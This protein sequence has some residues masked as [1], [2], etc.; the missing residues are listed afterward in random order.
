V[1]DLSKVEAGRMDL[2]LEIF[3]VA[4]LLDDVQATVQPLVAHK[5]NTLLVEST[6]DV[7]RMHA[8]VTK[9]RQVLFNL[10]SNAAK[11]TEHGTVSL[12]ASREGATLC[13]RVSDTGIGIAPQN[14]GKLFQPFTQVDASTTRKYGGTGLGLALT[15]RF[16]EL[17]GGDVTV[18]STPG[19]GTTFTVTLPD[20]LEFVPALAT[21][22]PD[23]VHRT[24]PAVLVV[25]DDPVAREL[26]QG[27]L[28]REGYAVVC[29]AS[30]PDGLRLARELR[31]L[32]ITL[33]VLMPGS[34][35]WA[36]LSQL[37]ADPDTCDIPVVMVSMLDERR[38]GFTLG[39]VDYLTKPV[40]RARLAATLRRFH[41]AG[42]RHALVVED[43]AWTREA[44]C[45]A[46]Q[47]EGW[48]VDEAEN[49]RVGLDRVAADA[50]SV[51]LLD[52]AMPEMDGFEFLARLR[53]DEAHRS[54]P[55]VV[56]TARDLGAEERQQLA[57][58]ASA[59]F[60]K[61]ALGLDDLVKHLRHLIGE[62][63]AP[64]ASN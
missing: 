34:D 40:D 17:M 16:C 20:N 24:G 60:Q 35:G 26:M 49:G 62:P 13:F 48:Q 15:K 7:G 55:V 57:G 56:V 25:D 29:A 64:P 1:L 19:A 46:L 27:Y 59:V 23:V 9:V 53:A 39:A 61:E 45:D 5:V 8:D 6:P 18:E 33:D 47:A 44:L 50:P 4:S 63:V 37:K 36:V 11:F 3:D 30:G 12:A 52:L 32:A 51:I 43:D 28:E 22:R 42:S 41:A 38:L 2:Y 31:P 58:R 14:L 21:L 54:I 10:L